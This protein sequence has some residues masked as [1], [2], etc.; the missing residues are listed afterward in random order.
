M[1]IDVH[2]VYLSDHCSSRPII[3]HEMYHAMGF[4]HEMQR[5][6]RDKYITIH[7]ENILKGDDDIFYNICCFS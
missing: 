4:Y 5:Y 2:Y 3:L 7:W 6:D 1:D